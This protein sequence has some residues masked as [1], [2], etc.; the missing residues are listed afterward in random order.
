MKASKKAFIKIKKLNYMGLFS[1]SNVYNYEVL[2]G[3][4]RHY[5]A[6]VVRVGSGLCGDWDC[7]KWNAVYSII[8]FSI[9][10]PQLPFIWGKS[11]SLSIK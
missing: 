5:S 7:Q 6:I 4:K 3:K 9:H 10:N 11:V 8:H 2:I 1:E